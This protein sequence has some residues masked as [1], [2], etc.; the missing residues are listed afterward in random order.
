MGSKTTTGIL[1]FAGGALTGAAVGLLF[2]PE[3]GRETR[4]W[5]SYQLEKYREVLADLTESLV[6]S[7]GEV[8]PT[9]SAKTEGQRVIQDA[10]SKAEQLLGDV[11]QLINQINSRKAL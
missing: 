2:A 3:K 8:G 6:T 4:S 5:L 1:C 10:K 11:D 9:S 7:R